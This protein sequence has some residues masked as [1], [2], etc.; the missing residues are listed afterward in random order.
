MRFHSYD[1]GGLLQLR[2]AYSEVVVEGRNDPI[3][4]LEFFS[5]SPWLKPGDSKPA[6]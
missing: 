6:L 2:F 3:L 5:F 1:K 4:V